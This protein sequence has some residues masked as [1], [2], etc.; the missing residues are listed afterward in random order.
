MNVEPA[1][2]GDLSRVQAAYAAGRR[3]QQER[4]TL[5]WP[6]FSDA[7]LIAEVQAGQLFRVMDNDAMVG[8]FVIAYEDAAV[9]GDRDRGAHVYLHRIARS[10]SGASGLLH[11]VIDWAC[12][13]SRALQREG[14]RMD[15]AAA[16]RQLVA[17]YEQA[18]FV[19]VGRQVIGVDPTLPS[20]YHGTEVVLFEMSLPSAV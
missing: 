6:N 5:V 16:S 12:A 8:T 9:W 13:H 7:S 4:G 14:I 17:Y 15:T 11:V 1:S 20:H 2:I 19:V 3:K 10:P 18:G